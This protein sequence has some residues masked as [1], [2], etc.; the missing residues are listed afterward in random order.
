MT[1]VFEPDAILRTLVRHGV[2]FVVVGGLAGNIRGSADVTNDLD[3]C[4]AR[5]EEN[6]K[7]LADSLR[8]LGA[9]LRVAPEPNADLPFQ[10]DAATLKA[11]DTFTFATEHGDLDV[12]ATP[13]G[14]EGFEDLDRSATFVELSD[15]LSV[16]VASIDDLIRMKRAAGRTKDLLQLEHLAALREEIDAFR[17]RGLDP[18]QGDP[19]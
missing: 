15:G 11:G 1:L 5:D 6:L 8:E 16:R 13:R 19:G 14:T 4:Y 12:L 18:Q 3:I 17:A 7:R 2:R 10:L 9:H